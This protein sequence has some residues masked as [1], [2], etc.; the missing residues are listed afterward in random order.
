M[1]EQ[2]KKTKPKKTN[3]PPAGCPWTSTSGARSGRLRVK[4]G[5]GSSCSKWERT[6][7]RSNNT[8]PGRADA[9][10]KTTRRDQGGYHAMV[11]DPPKRDGRTGGKCLRAHTGAPPRTT[12][13]LTD[14]RQDG[15][16]SG[17][18]RPPPAPEGVGARSRIPEGCGVTPRS[19]RTH[20]AQRHS[21]ERRKSEPQ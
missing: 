16:R 7:R 13:V 2:I 4:G 18:R 11:Q 12:Q 10:S 20:S 9:K 6:A 19:G 17:H 8:L 3:E 14:A 1:A 5:K 15:Q 21:S